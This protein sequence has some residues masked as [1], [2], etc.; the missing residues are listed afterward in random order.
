MVDALPEIRSYKGRSLWKKW[1]Q[2]T[3]RR[4]H[5]HDKVT[6]ALVGKY[7]D[8]KDSY[9]SVEKSLQHAAISCN[10][11]VDIKWVE[12]SNL[13]PAMRHSNPMK[14]HDAWKDLCAAK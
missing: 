10:R 3:Q 6:I 11:I 8:L 13:E 7:T 5:V 2:M 4:E 9:I 14:Y 12:A 1:K